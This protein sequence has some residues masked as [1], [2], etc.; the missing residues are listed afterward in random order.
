MR[1]PFLPLFLQVVTGASATNSGLLMLPLMAGLMTTSITSGRIIS[2]TGRYKVWPMTGMAV[3][4]VRHHL[5]L[6]IDAYDET[7]RTFP[8]TTAGGHERGS[9]IA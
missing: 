3:H 6:E 4:S 5:R 7:I 2:R 9:Q 8:R 1:P